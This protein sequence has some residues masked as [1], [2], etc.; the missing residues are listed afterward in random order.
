MYRAPGTASS[1][2]LATLLRKAKAKEKEREKEGH[3]GSGGGR[4]G[5]GRQGGSGGID[6]FDSK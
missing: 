1:P 2:D 5:H 3:S 6:T 4:D